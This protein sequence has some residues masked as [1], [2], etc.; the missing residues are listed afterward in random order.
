[1]RRVRCIERVALCEDRNKRLFK[2]VRQASKL[3]GRTVK[4]TSMGRCMAGMWRWQRNRKGRSN[5]YIHLVTRVF[6][7]HWRSC[8]FLSWVS[9]VRSQPSKC[10]DATQAKTVMRP[11]CEAVVYLHTLGEITARFLQHLLFYMCTCNALFCSTACTSSC[12][13]ILVSAT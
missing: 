9:Q 3:V 8:T 5:Q 10:F 7:C 1:M 2:L 13:I 11:L 6:L 12:N 4:R